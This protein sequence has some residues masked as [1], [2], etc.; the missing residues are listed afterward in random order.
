MNRCGE[1]FMKY[2]LENRET[3]T[4]VESGEPERPK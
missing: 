3:Y 1:Q 2:K 4:T